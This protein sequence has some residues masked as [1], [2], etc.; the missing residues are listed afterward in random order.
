MSA[1]LV[2]Y[3]TKH[4]STREVAGAITAALRERG[5]EV[6]LRPAGQ[7]RDSVVG[8]DLIVLGAPI[9]SGRWHGDAHR[10]L[11]RH[12]RELLQIPVA[13]Y[14]MG[15][16]DDNDDAWQSAREQLNNAL[17]KHGWFTAAATAVF[18]GVDPP[19]RHVTNRRDLRDWNAIRD[20]AYTMAAIASRKTAPDMASSL[21]FR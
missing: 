11:K 5:C 14:G 8:N 2:A 20:W 10:F 13:V 1:I 18:G 16:R 9:Y 12:R 21:E 6:N 4:G 3:A 19:K 15:P 7:I 17:A